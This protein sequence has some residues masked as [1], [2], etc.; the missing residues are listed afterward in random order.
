MSKVDLIDNSWVDLVFENKNKNYGAYQLRKETGKRNVKAMVIVFSTIAI[1]I[2]LFY[3]KIAIENAM[4]KKVAIET[5]VEL[6]KLAQKKEA[7]VERKEPVKVE[8]EQ[9]VI[10]KVKS[11]VKFTAPEIKKDEDVKPEDEIKSQDDLAKTNTAI[12][13]FDVK[14]NDEAAGEVLKAKEV[15][16]D[17]KPKEE[18]TKVFDVVEQ[19]P[20][21]PGGQGALFEYLSKQIK[22]PVIAEENG[23]QGRV[24]VTFV[25]ERDGSITDVKVV[26]S[27]DPSLD[28][29]AQRVVKG[30][31]RWIPGKQNGSA[32]RVKYTV[33]VTFRLQ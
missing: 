3:A 32:V 9:K 18:E 11:S 10:E 17:E 24:I 6:S 20:Q 1:V 8:Q 4:P 13:S 16:A 19:M 21:F 26:K 12:G 29:E 2:A 22:Y 15:I 31:P 7:K 27:V 23:V 28:K 30:M 33:P 25:V 5:D 14:G